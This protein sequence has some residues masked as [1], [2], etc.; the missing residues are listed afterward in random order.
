MVADVVVEESV[1][2]RDVLTSAAVKSGLL[3]REVCTGTTATANTCGMRRCWN[4]SF[5]KFCSR[6]Y[7][8]DIFY[9]LVQRALNRLGFDSQIEQF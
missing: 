3:G 7:G 1:I 8:H 5:R 9:F 4:S 2:P 6:T